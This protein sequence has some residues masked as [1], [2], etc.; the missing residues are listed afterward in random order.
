MGGY[1][2][3]F[4]AS[5]GGGL[6][7]QEHLASAGISSIA[8]AREA[9]REA[10]TAKAMPSIRRAASPSTNNTGTKTT[11]VVRVDA[12]IAPA[13]WLVPVAAAVRAESPSPRRR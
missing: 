8:T 9:S 4:G 5:K 2:H 7:W 11:H 6:L 12:V 13:T 1:R 3:A 10:T